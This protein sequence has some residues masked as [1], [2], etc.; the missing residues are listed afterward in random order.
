[1]SYQAQVVEILLAGPG[2]VQQERQEIA[3]AIDRW[4]HRHARY[5]GITMQPVMWETDTYPELGDDPQAIVNRQ[6]SERCVALIA[7]FATRL[8]TPTPRAPSGTVEE[9]DRFQR[10][11]KSV[12]VYFSDGQTDLAGIDTSQLAAL[13]DYRKYL[14]GRGLFGS[15]QSVS[16]FREQID[17]QIAHLGHRFQAA[18]RAQEPQQVNTSTTLEPNATDMGVL[19]VVGRSMVLTSEPYMSSLYL[20]QTPELEGTSQQAIFESIR[21]L[22]SRN[23]VHSANEPGYGR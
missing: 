14:R 4:N 20:Q 8:G 12:A 18:Q 2:D 22:K 19:A 9:I 23:L 15:Y 10:E 16:D 21:V 1:M 3:A 6:I 5:M 7:V 13:R 17:D 11:G